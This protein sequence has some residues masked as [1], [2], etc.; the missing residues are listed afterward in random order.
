MSPSTFTK[1]A[2]RIAVA[3]AAVFTLTSHLSPALATPVIEPVSFDAA[4]YDAW[5]DGLD[6][7]HRALIVQD[8]RLGEEA[9]WFDEVAMTSASWSDTQMNGVLWSSPWAGLIDHC[10]SEVREG[11]LW[12]VTTLFFTSTSRAVPTCQPITLWQTEALDEWGEPAAGGQMPGWVPPG[13][14]W[15]CVPRTTG[16]FFHSPATCEVDGVEYAD[17]DQMPTFTGLAEIPEPATLAILAAAIP[18]MLARARR[19][20]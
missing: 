15:V 12:Q 6:G 2:L 14:W 19:R 10:P 8:N 4:A 3:V 1:A 5:G 7:D 11:I 20:R 13:M 17:G 16:S 18:A 9:K